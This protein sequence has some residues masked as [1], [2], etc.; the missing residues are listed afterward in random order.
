MTAVKHKVKYSVDYD[1]S[2]DTL[3]EKLNI[4]LNNIITLIRTNNPEILELSRI[5]YGSDEMT[6]APL[7]NTSNNSTINRTVRHSH[8]V[9]NGGWYQSDLVFLGLSKNNL[10]LSIG[11]IDN[12][13]VIAMNI[14]PSIESIYA[15]NWDTIKP[16][17]SLLDSTKMFAVG[18][19]SRYSK[20]DD[21]ENLNDYN[22]FFPFIIS[23]KKIEISV[24]YWTGNNSSGYMFY[25]V[26]RRTNDVDLVFYKSLVNGNNS[27]C[28]ALYRFSKE[29]N[30]Y[31]AVKPQLL[32][33]SFDENVS[34]NLLLDKRL[35]CFFGDR[36][37]LRGLDVD[38]DPVGSNSK[39]NLR[40]WFALPAY[41]GTGVDQTGHIGRISCLFMGKLHT[42]GISSVSLQPVPTIPPSSMPNYD[43]VKTFRHLRFSSNSDSGIRAV[44]SPMCSAYSLPYLEDE[45]E[46]YL[47]HVRVPGFIDNCYG[48]LYMMWTPSIYSYKSGNIVEIDN[49]KYVV[50]NEGVVC[51]VAKV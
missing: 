37:G 22:L 33:F 46:I 34:D 9:E 15:D 20:A 21:T 19:A 1:R 3:S 29:Y 41:T 23:N 18:L 13:L 10:V 36:D 43:N 8:F 4:L 32:T 28:C 31:I 49:D 51:W 2:T 38:D 16:N 30:N 50:I 5:T 42:L 6:G 24:V 44:I 7:Y 27:L 45:N 25:D 39:Y 48:E 11:F 26:Q 12:K 35:P 17:T 47:R 14:D 40:L